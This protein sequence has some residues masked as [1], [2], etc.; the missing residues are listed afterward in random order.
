MKPTSTKDEEKQCHPI[1]DE[2]EDEDHDNVPADAVLSVVLKAATTCAVRAP[3]TASSVHAILGHP[4]MTELQL[5][6]RTGQLR[7]VRLPFKFADPTTCVCA[8]CL[9][10]KPR[11]RSHPDGDRSHRIRFSP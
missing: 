3:A 1:S 2:G 10:T 8:T 11:W 9:I 7:G 5:W 6:L 4:A